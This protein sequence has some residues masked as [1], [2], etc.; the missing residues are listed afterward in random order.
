MTF[1]VLVSDFYDLFNIRYFVEYAA[2]KHKVF[3]FLLTTPLK[4]YR[5][6]FSKH[7]KELS[8]ICGFPKS[9]SVIVGD[10]DAYHS[11]IKK[12]K[13]DFLI[14]NASSYLQL[15]KFNFLKHKSNI[16]KVCLVTWGFDGTD[17]EFLGAYKDADYV[18][19]E[20]PR[21]FDYN[22]QKCLSM[23]GHKII[24]SHPY[25]D[26]FSTLDK[27]V[28]RSKLNITGQQNVVV[29]PESG[30]IS[31]PS[32]NWVPLYRR[33]IETVKNHGFVLFKG[34]YKAE[35]NSVAKHIKPNVNLFVNNEWI[36]PPLGIQCCMASDLCVMPCESKFAL[37]SLMSR[38]PTCLFT[39]G[40]H[41]SK[42]ATNRFASLFSHITFIDIGELL[43]DQYD[44][45]IIDKN[46]KI[47]TR[48]AVI[49]NSPS[50]SEYLLNRII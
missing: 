34:R 38:R 23:Y 30:N 14:G 40:K 33:V 21:F 41:K 15:D 50:N 26:W 5:V 29:I 27:K 4:G 17:D 39:K 24:Y 6:L 44:H 13:I 16:G 1:L 11:W 10:F 47:L 46:Y 2:T 43:S 12:N 20:G 32:K 7:R 18:V 9:V 3:L 49:M 25:Y 42:N 37:E 19:V 31:N 28:A 35:D 45:T 48:D 8:K 36:S 22:G